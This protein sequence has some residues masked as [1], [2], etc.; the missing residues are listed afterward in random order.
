MA[1]MTRTCRYE[2]MNIE[3]LFARGFVLFGGAVWTV[4][5]FVPETVAR[6]TEFAHTLE[7]VA[8]IAGS[9]AVPLAAAI[10][11]FVVGLFYETL[12]ALILLVGVASAV[13]W[14]ITAGWFVSIWVIMGVTL[15]GPMLLAAILFLL[16]ASMQAICELE[17][18]PDV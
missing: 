11:V 18:H 1:V 16:A 7:G 2:R 12:A 14:G 15:I 17:G 13:G 9:A 10:F 8:A 4:I 5:L 6:F 3:R